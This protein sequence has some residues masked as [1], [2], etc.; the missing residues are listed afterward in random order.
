MGFGKFGTKEAS[1]W[2][3]NEPREL[4]TVGV[5]LRKVNFNR[6]LQV[7]ASGYSHQSLGAAVESPWVALVGWAPFLRSSTAFS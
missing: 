7:V 6:P 5:G 3:Q 2:D 1:H 4:E